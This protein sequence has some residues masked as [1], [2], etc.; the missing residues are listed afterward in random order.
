MKYEINSKSQGFLQVEDVQYIV[1]D[2]NFYRLM[3]KHQRVL[4][5]IPQHDVSMIE[6]DRTTLD[7]IEE[8]DSET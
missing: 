7:V 2:G 8:L 3:D 1:Q 5:I 4:L 6:V